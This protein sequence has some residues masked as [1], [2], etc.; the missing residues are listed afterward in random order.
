MIWHI[1]I[2]GHAQREGDPNGTFNNWFFLRE[3]LAAN[4]CQV[5]L[6][7]WNSNWSALAERIWLVWQRL[8]GPSPLINAYAYSWGAGWGFQQFAGELAKRG[9]EIAQAVL[10]DPVYRHR[11]WL[12]QW[13]ALWP[14]S[15]ILIAPNVREVR[16]LFQ[17]MNLPAGHPVVAQDK[18]HTKIHAGVRLERIH[19]YMDEAPEFRA[20][21]CE[22]AGVE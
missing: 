17:R 9:M 1:C 19:H 21:I 2:S 8:G 12:G 6:R 4:Q 7:E 18:C 5:E 16:W 15:Q 13:R 11:Y 10:C 3:R 20:M 22:A 14:F